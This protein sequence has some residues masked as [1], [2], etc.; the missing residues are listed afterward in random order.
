MIGQPV[1]MSVDPFDVWSPVVTSWD[2][3]DGSSG[4]GATVDHCYSSPGERTVTI[5]GT[6]P[7]ANATSASQMISIEPNP[8][9]GTGTDSCAGPGPP[10]QPGPPNQ[11]GSPDRGPHPGLAVP[12][13]SDLR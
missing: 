3:G 4:L 7:A 5:T 1:A 10:D 6:D 12:V 11:A 9:L 2:F 8:E 13:L